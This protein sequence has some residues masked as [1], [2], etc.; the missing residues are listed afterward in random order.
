M[1]GDRDPPHAAAVTAINVPAPSPLCRRCPTPPPCSAGGKGKSSDTGAPC[2]AGPPET[3]PSA[4]A[5]TSSH[6]QAPISAWACP[7][8][9]GCRSNN[10][11]STPGQ[12]HCRGVSSFTRMGRCCPSMAW[13][14]QVDHAQPAAMTLTWFNSIGGL[15]RSNT[16]VIGASFFCSNRTT[17]CS[18]FK[19][20][21]TNKVGSP[22]AVM[23]YSI[24]PSSS[25]KSRLISHVSVCGASG[26]NL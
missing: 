8:C 15:G 25:L 10:C 11:S 16:A 20:L 23:S 14:K 9:S 17:N 13:C 3:P 2:T 22:T 4:P 7:C 26:G 1:F 5:P 19:S 12:D 18:L 24:S 21:L 6:C